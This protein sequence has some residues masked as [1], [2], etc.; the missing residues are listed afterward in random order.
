MTPTSVMYQATIL[1]FAD[2]I[3]LFHL[4]DDLFVQRKNIAG[5][6]VGRLVLL[7]EEKGV[8]VSKQMF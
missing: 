1:F 6:D 2:R 5:L 7:E 4:A 8:T 3:E